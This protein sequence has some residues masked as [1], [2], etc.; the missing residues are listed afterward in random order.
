MT[1]QKIRR[2][3][4]G[5]AFI[6]YA[7]G[8]LMVIALTYSY[9]A[10]SPSNPRPETGQ[11]QKFRVKGDVVYI[12]AKQSDLLDAVK[13]WGLIIAFCSALGAGLIDVIADRRREKLK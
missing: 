8:T 9:L 3:L 12:T 10:L 4:I 11:I 13:L 2:G 6:S 7:G 1:S 5:L